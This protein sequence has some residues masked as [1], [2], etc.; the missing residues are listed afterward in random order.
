MI[1]YIIQICTNDLSQTVYSKFSECTTVVQ[2]INPSQSLIPEGIFHTVADIMMAKSNEFSDIHGMMGMFHCVKILLKCAGHYLRRSDFDDSLVEIQ[3]SGKPDPE[4]SFGW[5]SL[6]TSLP[7]NH[8]GL[9]SSQ[10]LGLGSI[11][12]LVGAE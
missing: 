7:W 1:P 6:F 11:L 4:F 2:Q 8:C 9:R 12:G 5:E 3:V 10:F